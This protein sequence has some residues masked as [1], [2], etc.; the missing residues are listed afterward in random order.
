MPPAIPVDLSHLPPMKDLTTTNITPNVI[1]INNQ[2]PSPR[3]RY[4]FERLVTH[5]HD[6][7]RETRLSTAEWMLGLDFLTSVGQASSDL[8]R[9][10]ILLSDTLGLSALVD[11]ID[12]PRTKESTEGTVLGPFHT[13]DALE[14]ENGAAVHTDPL[15]EAL[16]VLGTVRGTDGRAIEGCRIDVWEGDSQGNYDVQYP[17]RNGPDG[18][19]ILYSDKQGAFWFRCVKPVSYPIPLDGP[20]AEMLRYLGRHPNRPGH[21][22][23]FLRKDGYDPLITALYPRGDP[24]EASDPVFGVKESLIVDYTTVDAEMAKKYGVKEGIAAI[25]YD[26]V[27]VTEEETKQ[28]RKQEALQ[29]IKQ[30]GR[31]LEGFEGL[32]VLDVD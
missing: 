31:S 7:A 27:L 25:T 4:I 28:L 15:G 13:H 11:A 16:F 17:D 14:V 23:F 3:G 20:V 26:F 8:R 29:A 6:F 5:L 19:G 24:H 32:P 22:H 2:C 1:L 9:E 10:M 12:H 21:V 30:M 18:R